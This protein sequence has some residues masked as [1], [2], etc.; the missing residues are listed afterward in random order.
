MKSRTSVTV[1]PCGVPPLPSWRYGATTTRAPPVEPS[2]M[3]PALV[4]STWV[5]PGPG[6]WNTWA[7]RN[8]GG[9]PEGCFTGSSQRFLVAA[10]AET[11][12]TKPCCWS[13][14]WKLTWLTRPM[15]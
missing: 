6:S 9:H 13:R 3:L 10:P 5:V 11:N 1:W 4:A 7:D 12:T 2:E 14:S 15:S 8:R